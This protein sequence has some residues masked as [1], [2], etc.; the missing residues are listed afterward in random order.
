MRRR[1]IFF[2][3]PISSPL[4]V[5]IITVELD[6]TAGG[7]SFILKALFGE[8]KKKLWAENIR[9]GEQVDSPGGFA[10]HRYSIKKDSCRRKVTKGWEKCS[11]RS[12]RT[13]GFVT[14]RDNNRLDLL[15]LYM[16]MPS[17]GQV[18][19]NVSLFPT[20]P[21]CYCAFHPRLPQRCQNPIWHHRGL[22]ST[23]DCVEQQKVNV[24]Y[25]WI[26]IIIISPNQNKS[27][28]CKTL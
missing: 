12:A 14:D 26:I 7:I 5:S 13:I 28:F 2:S 23:T 17:S 25:N 16:S 10:P 8:R 4:V 6:R 11:M 18:T 3:T 22:P 1:L 21:H 9:H 24:G 27:Y 15:H 19:W 20:F